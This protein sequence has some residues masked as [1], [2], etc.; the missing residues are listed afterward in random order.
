MMDVGT[1]VLKQKVKVSGELDWVTDKQAMKPYCLTLLPLD[2]MAAI[3]QTTFLN[4]FSWLKKFDFWLKFYW[5]LFL[6]VQ[7]KITGI[8]LDNGLVPMRRQAIIWINDDP[9]HW[10]LYAT[11]G[12]DELTHWGRNK[13][14]HILHTTLNVF[15]QWK[16]FIFWCTFH[17][18]VPKCVLDKKPALT[19]VIMVMAWCKK[20]DNH[21]LN[22]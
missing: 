14:A 4:A 1:K 17:W 12:G 6:R 19:P 10:R 3:L 7:M 5:N 16:F 22:Q 9:I 8:G 21:Y 18:C 13:M 11:L 15:L 20:H 2:K